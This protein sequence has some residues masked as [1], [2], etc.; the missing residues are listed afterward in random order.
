[1]LIGWEIPRSKQVDDSSIQEKNLAEL[2]A[3]LYSS[4][5]DKSYGITWQSDSGLEVGIIHA[6]GQSK[7][8][9]ASFRAK[10]VIGCVIDQDDSIPSVRFYLNGEVVLPSPAWISE[11]SLI[12]NSS[13][14]NGIQIQN[15]AY[16]LFP[17][18]SMYSSKKRPLMRV[19]F[20]F[21]GDFKF[22]IDGYEPYGA[23]L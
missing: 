5:G 2:P 11:H 6:N 9:V 18:V 8:G 3:G 13:H 4:S 22:P 17:A 1:L 23:P 19:R 7:S 15:S 10:D 14:P 16:C 21:R 20:N 12:K